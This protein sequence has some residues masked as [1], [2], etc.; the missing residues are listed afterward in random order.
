MSGPPYSRVMTTAITNHDGPTKT[1]TPATRPSR[2]APAGVGAS[3][4]VIAST[5]RSRG[6]YGG[7]GNLPPEPLHMPQ[8]QTGARRD[9]LGRSPVRRDGDEPAAWRQQPDRA[10]HVEG[11]PDDDDLRALVGG[12]RGVD[13]RYAAA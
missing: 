9:P 12:C 1:G 4:S 7:P 11:L 5:L 10:R 13:K 6:A 2:T 3:G 8:R